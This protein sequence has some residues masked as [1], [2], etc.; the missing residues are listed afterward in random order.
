MW[1]FWI[2]KWLKYLYCTAC[3]FHLYYQI[4]L[5]WFSVHQYFC[6]SS[7]KCHF[8]ENNW[9]KSNTYFCGIIISSC[10]LSQ[11]SFKFPGSTCEH[12]VSATPRRRL[13]LVLDED[14][15]LNVE[16]GN[17]ALIEKPLLTTQIKVPLVILYCITVVFLCILLII[18]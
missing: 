10:H 4:N 13:F 3:S 8:K 2:K 18:T 11:K 17:W 6:F 7:L 12:G 9:G 1:H 15:L 14:L 16:N 5:L